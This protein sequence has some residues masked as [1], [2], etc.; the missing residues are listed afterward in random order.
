MKSMSSLII[1]LKDVQLCNNAQVRQYV[2]LFEIGI[3]FFN[4]HDVMNTIS[5]F[6]FTLKKS[7]NWQMKTHQQMKKVSYLIKFNYRNTV[8][9]INIDC[10]CVYSIYIR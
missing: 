4:L 5:I 1:S 9:S 3:A 8:A 7:L 6:I 10:L 2:H